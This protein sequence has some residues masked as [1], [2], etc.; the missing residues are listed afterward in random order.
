MTRE[1]IFCSFF[2]VPTCVTGVC[3]SVSGSATLQMCSPPHPL[4]DGKLQRLDA[5]DYKCMM[6]ASV[7]KTF[8]SAVA[9]LCRTH[10]LSRPLTPGKLQTHDAMNYK[11]KSG[12]Y[13]SDFLVFLLVYI[14][15]PLTRS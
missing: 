1:I 3:M 4:T 15:M 11:Y 7:F 13:F 10:P 12:V 6:S 9:Y 8:I 2:L 14:Q 5:V